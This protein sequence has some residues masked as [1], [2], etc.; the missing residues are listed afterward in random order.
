MLAGLL[1]FAWTFADA[2][3]ITVSRY[4]DAN[5]V[6]VEEIERVRYRPDGTY[7]SETETW[8]KLLTEKGRRE[9]STC[10]LDYSR[11]YG[12]AE[13]VYVGAIDTNGVER[14]IDVSAT[15]KESTDNGSMAANIYDPLDRKLVATIPGL[16]IGEILHVKCRRRTFKARCENQWADFCVFEWTCPIVSS[17]YEVTAPAALPIRRFA[18]RHPLGNVTTNLTRHADGSATYAF[19][20]TNSAQVFPEPDMPPLHTQVQHLRISTAADWPEISRWYWALCEPHLVKTNAALVAKAL[21][22]KD[23]RR[24][25][26][27][28]SQEI[29]YMGLTL[30]D[31]SPGYSPHDVDLTFDN[32]Y[33]VCRDKAALLVAMLRA[34]GHAA[35]PVLINVGAKLD[36]EVPQPYFNHAIVAVETAAEGERRYLLMDPT[37]ENAKDLLPKYLSDL[38]YL[39]C[40]PEGEQLLTSPVP[41]PADNALAV[42]TRG[43]LAKDGSVFAES[44]ITMNGINDT[45]YRHALVKKTPELCERFFEQAVQAVQPGAEL[46]RCEITPA[47]L[48]DTDTP[49]AVE[50]QVR[51]PE[52]RLAGERFD[53]LEV[54]L[55]TRALGV[56]NFLLAG[57]T[58]LAQRKYPLRLDTTAEVSETVELALGEELGAVRQLPSVAPSPGAFDYALEYSVTNAVLTAR[59]RNAL[60][61][62]EFSPTEYGELRERLKAA[63]ASA[64]QRCEF[65]CD[66]L[67]AANVRYWLNET[68]TSLLGERSWVTTNRVVKQVLTYSGKR[69]SAELSFA[70]NPLWKQVELV[71]AVVSNADGRVAR[72]TPKEM[73]VMD[74]GWVSAAPRYPASKLLVV[75]LP[76]VEIGS[77]IA[78]TVVT[79]VTNAP[80]G[81]YGAYDFDSYEPTECRRVRVGDWRREVLRPRRLEREPAQPPAE[82]WRDR[83]IVS[84]CRFEEAEL[85]IGE[86]EREDL[87]D[88][89]SIRDWM[90]RNVKVAGPS[91][92]ELPLAAQ[93]TPPATVLKERYA[94]RLDYVRTLAALCR[95]AGYDAEVVFAAADADSPASVRERIMRT[96]PAVSEFSIPLCRVDDRYFLGIENQYAEIGTSAWAGCDYYEP[97]EGEFG[98]VTVPEARYEDRTV[99]RTVYAVRSDGAVDIDSERRLYGSEVGAF[100]KLYSEILPEERWR[101]YQELLGEISQAATATGELVTDTEGYPAVRK[102]SCYVPDMATVGKGTLTLR[103][104]PLESSFRRLVGRSRKTPV[105]IAA[106]AA[107]TETVVVRFPAGYVGVEHLPA[108]FA[109][110]DPAGGGEWLRQRTTAAVKDGALEVTIERQVSRRGDRWFS[111]AYFELFKDWARIADSA[112]NRTVSVRQGE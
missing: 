19:V 98:V 109:F 9:E 108:D 24:L 82:F 92:W 86:I 51:Y 72:V 100:R 74:A 28:V 37:D 97:E 80:V 65:E 15:M 12:E 52:M 105:E 89:R 96:Q 29:R 78:Y 16:Q 112:A 55:L 26:R 4:P 60:A 87:P 102:F 103:L 57:N 5:A 63:E 33:G 88:L 34:A 104:P 70:Y 11:R 90:A 54:P 22:L 8:T 32:R 3:A 43:A 42:R 58:A 18:I 107:A 76:S 94:S 13:I 36:P 23:V 99:E 20:A 27:F 64:R 35:F 49:L 21:E 75:N 62:L 30:E 14:V 83:E 38:S 17:V 39:V 73:N 1:L 48:R 110:A 66:G 44:R 47:D 81:F 69:S 7:E 31:Q 45:A 106:W 111:P 71:E 95:G 61:A 46:V 59:R 56:V 50:L 84:H 6:T 67:K 2:E 25:F 79:T 93:L 101:R 68:E 40:R 53:T 77:V 91:L 85:D 41:P 10:R